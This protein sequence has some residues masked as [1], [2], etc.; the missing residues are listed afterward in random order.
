M[1]L[2]PAEGSSKANGHIGL[3]LRMLEVEPSITVTRV[4][5][6]SEDHEE[7]RFFVDFDYT[8]CAQSS[9]DIFLSQ[10]RPAALYIPIF[11]LVALLLRTLLP[12]SITR[13]WYDALRVIVAVLLCPWLPLLFR[14]QAIRLYAI[15]ENK[16]LAAALSSIPA[17]RL[18]IVSFGFDFIIRGLLERSRLAKAQ[19]VAPSLWSV[20]SW[21]RE[22]KLEVLRQAQLLP[23]PEI[24][25]VITDSDEDDADLLGHVQHG[26]FTRWPE[27]AAPNPMNVAYVPFYY[28]L[29]IKRSPGFFVKQVLLEE[30]MI[31]LLV[32]GLE[33]LLTD[34]TVLVALALLFLS[35]FVMYEIGYADN[36]RVGFAKETNPKLSPLFYS[37]MQYVKPWSALVWSL[38]FGFISIA[39]LSED[40]RQGIFLRAGIVAPESRLLEYSLLLFGWMNCVTL[41]CFLFWV[42]NRASLFWRVFLYLPLQ[43]SKILSPLIFFPIEPVGAALF[44]AHL[45]RMWAP[46]A[47]RRC[48]G[49]FENTSSQVIRLAFVVAFLPLV[50][51]AQGD[52][53]LL[54]QWEVGVILIFCL[55]RSGPEV[56]RKAFG[57]SL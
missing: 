8:L 7:R 15:H 28:T 49:D 6:L 1:L 27:S 37:N 12:K 44:M 24:D 22:G 50:A 40:I 57:P 16:Q 39:I 47:I 2:Y 23:N 14:K 55:L 48:G 9:T 11:K 3:P 42:F 34:W 46:Y 36:D 20:A 33:F 30:L 43:I 29:R 54:L 41:G 35:Y 5:S 32:F 51:L 38:V 18:T 17:E 4:R 45:V 10:A 19:L 31:V 53:S 52:L 25:V 13:Y 21:R 56:K 26:F